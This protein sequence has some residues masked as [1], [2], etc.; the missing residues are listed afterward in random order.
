MANAI[1]FCGEMYPLDCG[2]PF[3]IGRSGDL[4]IDDNPYLHRS[5]LCLE[6]A[7]DLWW[8]SNV[9]ATLSASVSDTSG[10]FHA[11]LNP[12]GRIPLVFAEAT[13]WFTA[14]PTTYELTIHTAH[15]P[16][17]PALTEHAVGTGETTGKPSPLSFE[18]RLLLV[19]LAEPML[20]RQTSRVE[21]PPSAEVAQR[22]GWPVTKLNRKLDN[23]CA[24]LGRAGVRGLHGGPDRLAADRKGRL[25]EY[26]LSARLVRVE[27]L[28]LL[29]ARNLEMARS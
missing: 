11:W 9:G 7:M 18:Q 29:E 14:G 24:K 10:L 3:T 2:V 13:V 22:L 4:A 26:A 21:V 27:D 20:R 12:G 23:L 15:A 5:F 6:H 28:A 1:E 25:V 17:E 16:F 19:A 8:V